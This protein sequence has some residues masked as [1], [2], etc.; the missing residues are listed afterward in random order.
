MMASI[1]S[2]PRFQ[3]IEDAVLVTHK[4]C[5]DGSG[6]KIMFLRAGGDK[7]SIYEVNAG[8]VGRFINRNLHDLNDKFLIFADVGFAKDHDDHKLLEKR[9][10]CVLLDHHNT[11]SHLTNESWCLI[12]QEKCGTELLRLYL[13]LS[14][15]YSYKLSRIIQDD[16]LWT[17]KIP[18][19]DD[20]S[21]FHAFV[22]SDNFVDR[23][24]YGRNVYRES[25]F[26]V[27]EKE[28]VSMIGDRKERIIEDL[29][30]KV[31]E[32]QLTIDGSEISVGYIVSSD[33]NT[34]PLLNRLLAR[35]KDLD[36]A[37]QINVEK[38]SVSFRSR[39]YDVS[40]LAQLFGGGGHKRAAGHSISSDIL[41]RLIE[42]I[43]GI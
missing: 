33:N 40:K 8:E 31:R 5:L 4:N 22:G 11:A 18:E 13:E 20:L 17:K 34:S 9:G 38:G 15:D 24:R 29:I 43:H 39:D 2:L 28:I 35:R 14:D 37:C 6:A 27:D 30:G 26:D 7:S 42:D 36:V 10:N 32:K 1:K 21:A 19:S 16:D 3:N 23:F 41:E 12:D 25:I